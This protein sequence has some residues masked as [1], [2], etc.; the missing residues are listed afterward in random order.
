MSLLQVPSVN[1]SHYTH[2][3]ETQ[4][5]Q[6][7]SA[8]GEAFSTI[9]FVALSGHYLDKQLSENLYTAVKQFFALPEAVKMKYEIII[10]QSIK[11]SSIKCTINIEM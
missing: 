3:T 1:L 4:Q 9:G 11:L 7:V 2:G 6:F 10:S 5:Q 8:I